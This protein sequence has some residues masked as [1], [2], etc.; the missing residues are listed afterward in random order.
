ML[1]KP[2][3]LVDIMAARGQAFEHRPKIVNL[4]KLRPRHINLKKIFKPAITIT[5]VLYFTLSSVFFNSFSLFAPTNNSILA[6]QN[7]EERAELEAELRDLEEQIAKYEATLVSYKSQ[8]KTLK[9]EI[10]RLSAN[11]S[12][13][14]LQIKAVNLSI[15]QLD[16]NISKT[17]KEISVTEDEIDLHKSAITKL[18]R[19]INENET[20]S[21]IEILLANP[22]LSDFFGNIN[23]I[24]LIEDNLRIELAKVTS[25]RTDLLGQKEKLALQRNDAEAI[26]KYQNSQ[27]TAI[28][29]TKTQKD[30]LLAVTK[31]QE[32][33]YQELVKQTRATAAEIRNRIFRLLGGGELPFGEAV[34]LAQVAE[35]ATGVRASLILSV[36]TQE[37]SL[38]GVIGRNLGKCYYNTPRDNPSGTVMS[39]AQKPAFI[40]LIAELGLNPDTTP[41]SCPIA[42]DGAYGGAMGP[43][44]FMPLTW[45]LY[46]EKVGDITG[47]NPPSPFNNL[48]AFTATAVY[49][50]DGLKGCKTI[51]STI[52]SQEN[53]A[54]AKYYAGGN[55]RAYTALG[56]Y[57]YRV[58]ERSASFEEDIEVLNG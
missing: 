10:D 33:K 53:C 20:A 36:L 7:N 56:R 42:S 51:Y 28:Q 52:F 44:Q 21:I 27:K 46:Q 49:L 14:N 29:S 12:K 19:N 25:L 23:N 31:G 43:A 5:A 39:N 22:K 35:R 45:E 50:S 26:K 54:A 41:V 6:A 8:G 16:K 13:L 34:K 37:S 38:D 9:S 4:Y 1:N 40:A 30:E 48:D 57:G 18:I 17:S 15:T 11:I 32:M 24:L 55:W 3:N 58:A 2:K 47:G